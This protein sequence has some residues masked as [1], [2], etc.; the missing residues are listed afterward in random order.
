MDN[1]ERAGYDDLE[2]GETSLII[3]ISIVQRLKKTSSTIPPISAAIPRSLNSE[4]SFC[5]DNMKGIAFIMYDM[6]ALIRAVSH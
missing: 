5:L 1:Q 3:I 2:N 4:I 6:Y